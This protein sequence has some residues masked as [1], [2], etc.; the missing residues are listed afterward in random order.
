MQRVDEDYKLKLKKQLIQSAKIGIGSCIAMDIALALNLENAASAGIITLLSIVTTKWETLRLSVC[1]LITFFLSVALAW[2][3]FPN[4]EV[5]WMAYGIFIFI[6]VFFS[7]RAGLKATI[8]VNAVIGS[9]FLISRDFSPAFIQNE[10]LLL[11]IGISFAVVL[12]LFHGNE[13]QKSKIVSDI[14]YTEKRMRRILEE[15]EKYLRNIPTDRNA[16]EDINGMEKKLAIYIE[17]AYEY[18]NNTF[19]SHPEYY[20]NYFEMR[21]S[22]CEVLYSLHYEMQKIRHVP[23]QAE[24]IA[25]YIEYMRP[26]VQEKNNPKRQIERLETL[27]EDMKNQEMPED[28]DGLVCWAKL[29]HILMNLEEF[30]LFKQRFVEEIDAVQREIY[31]DN[32]DGDY[33]DMFY[34]E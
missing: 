20:I 4:I 14:L 10:F 27:F 16:W 23:K 8:S 32:E 9:H 3:I 7:E 11:L 18:Q 12:N 2:V 15:M 29:Y 25:D 34:D 31:W 22:Q 1:R 5:S 6:V 13:N 30:L 28:K 17:R 24:I 21:M 26:F 19:V 33:V